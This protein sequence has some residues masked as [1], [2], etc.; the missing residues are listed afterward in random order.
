MVVSNDYFEK[1]KK[2]VM[3]Y[4]FIYISSIWLLYTMFY[5]ITNFSNIFPR[6]LTVCVNIIFLL[7]VFFNEIIDLRINRGFFEGIF[8]IVLSL[9]VSQISNDWRFLFLSI[10]VF[11]SR[12]FKFNLVLKEFLFCS[13]FVMIFTICSSVIWGI[14]PN[15]YVLRPNGIRRYSLGYSYSTFINQ[16]FLFDILTIFLLFKEKIKLSIAVLLFFFNLLLFYWTNTKNPFFL[17][18]IIL[19]VAICLKNKKINLS[20]NKFIKI[21]LCLIFFIMFFLIYQICLHPTLSIYQPI[22]EFVNY[23]L[24]LATSAMNNYGVKILGQHIAWNTSNYGFAATGYNYVDSSYLN[25]LLTGGAVYCLYVLLGFTRVMWREW[26]RNNVYL[27]I[28]LLFVAIQAIFDPQLL[29]FY[30][31]PFSLLLGYNFKK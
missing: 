4:I 13:F 15:E 27:I 10:F 25:I 6:I 29:Y 30:F 26:D 11:A 31:S 12:K 8:F 9:I 7:M 5:Q 20:K 17:S 18:I 16:V 2:F 3:Q 28:T 24:Q 19:V 23:R 14:I 21:P 22:N 1:S